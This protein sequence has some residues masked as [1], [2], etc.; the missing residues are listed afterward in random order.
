MNYCN[1]FLE[2]DSPWSA[3]ILFDSM[4]RAALQKKVSLAIN[5]DDRIFPVISKQKS[6]QY[7]Q[8]K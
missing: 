7:I 8:N 5:N 3:F 4:E 6:L 1:A 2:A